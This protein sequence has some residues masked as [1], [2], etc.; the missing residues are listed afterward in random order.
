MNLERE[1]KLATRAARKAGDYLKGVYQ[2][3][4]LERY[5][6]DVKLNEDREAESIILDCLE[7]SHLPIISEETRPD[8]RFNDEMRWIVDPLDGSLNFL[9]KI[10]YCGVF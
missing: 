1:L 6:R 5:R 8:I 4:I 3:E 9:R 7:D 10:T 2:A